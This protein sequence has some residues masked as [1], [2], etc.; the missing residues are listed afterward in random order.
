MSDVARDTLPVVANFPFLHRTYQLSG[1]PLVIKRTHIKKERAACYSLLSLYLFSLSTL[2]LNK[3]CGEVC[4]EEKSKKTGFFRLLGLLSHIFSGALWSRR[5]N[6]VRKMRA[7][8]PKLP[9]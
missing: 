8:H 7:G 4:Q 3:L 2:L 1:A 6:L 9:K 5:Q